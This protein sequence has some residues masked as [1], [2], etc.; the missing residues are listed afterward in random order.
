VGVQKGDLLNVKCSLKSI[1][2]QIDGGA[3]TLVEALIE[4][5]GEEGTIVTDSF[6][7]VFPIKKLL[8][9]KTLVSTDDTPSYA[10]TIAN[11][12]VSYTGRYRSSHPVQRFVCIGKLAKQLTDNHKPESYAY[13]VLRVMA[14]N[15]GKNLKIGTDEKVVGVGTTHIA[16]GKLGLK[17]KRQDAGI[18]Y[19]DNNNQLKLFRRNWAGACHNGFINFVPFYDKV[20]AVLSRGKIGQSDCKITDMKKTLDIE[21]DLL[22]R[23]PSFFMCRS[24]YCIECQLSWTFSKGNFGRLALNIIASKRI[25]E[26]VNLVKYATTKKILQP[27]S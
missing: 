1:G 20:G 15:G 18:W 6:V 5:I 19:Y 14:E 13:D 7:T 9:D 10:G 12:M 23:D 16:I 3:K 11:A 2:H 17:Q 25:R 4:T 26:F 21:I 8:R 27:S 22:K 24:K